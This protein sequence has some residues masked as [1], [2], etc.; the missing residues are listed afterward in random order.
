MRELADWQPDQY[1]RI[2]CWPLR[3]ALLSFEQKQKR[4]AREEFRWESLIHAALAPH[5]K[6]ERDR[7]PP[8]PPEILKD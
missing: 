5:M 8:D 1:E 6:N 2:A 3:E 4:E 7:K